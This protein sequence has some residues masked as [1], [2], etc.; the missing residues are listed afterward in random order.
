MLTPL[1]R[2]LSSSSFKFKLKLR[3]QINCFLIILKIETA[4]FETNAEL[5]G[6]RMV[7]KIPSF[8]MVYWLFEDHNQVFI[9]LILMDQLFLVLMLL[10]SILLVIFQIYFMLLLYK[11][12]FL[13]FLLLFLKWFRILR[14]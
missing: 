7:T 2:L 9:D 6:Y 3:L 12:I 14:I 1:F 4:Y 11:N 13:Q 10:S 5:I 8:I